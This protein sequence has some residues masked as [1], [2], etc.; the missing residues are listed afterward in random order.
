MNNK[1]IKEINL[2]DKKFAVNFSLKYFEKLSTDK[3]IH[4]LKKN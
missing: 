2:K 4:D 1:K 3:L